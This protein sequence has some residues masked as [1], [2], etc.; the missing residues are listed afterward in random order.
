[1]PA[2]LA[3]ESAPAGSDEKTGTPGASI[4]PAHGLPGLRPKG[5]P[6][7]AS[8]SV[9]AAMEAEID[10]SDCQQM[11]RDI[12]HA[13]LPTRATFQGRGAVPLARGASISEEEE[14][15][16]AAGARARHLPFCFPRASHLCLLLFSFGFADRA[17]A[18]L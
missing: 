13:V 11:V 5:I 12:T 16:P 1:M 17:R 6:G 7:L 8:M 9:A 4:A 2:S 14:P 10:R 3:E 18:S 15:D